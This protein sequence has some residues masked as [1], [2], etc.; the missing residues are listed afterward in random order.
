[1]SSRLVA[2]FT[3]FE[4]L[5]DPRID[6]TR[7]HDLFE[8]IVVA[9]HAARLPGPTPGRTSSGLAMIGSP[10]CGRS[11]GSK[12]AS[13][14]HDTVGRVFAAAS[15]RLKLVACIQQWLDDLGGREI[16]KHIAIDGE[17]TCVARAT[18]PPAAIRC[19]WYRLGPARHA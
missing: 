6:R 7:I 10:G 4:N 2:V 16:S 1:M 12:V 14:R 3:P 15:I 19:T 8:L 18:R 9:L 17:T 5:A 13:L 11:C